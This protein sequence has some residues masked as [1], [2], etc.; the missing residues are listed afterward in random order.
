ML[1][2]MPKNSITALPRLK[3]KMDAVGENLRLA[4]LRRRL[5]ASQVSERAG[6]SRQTLSAAEHGDPGVSFGVYANVLFV[7]GLD[8]DL[9]AL[10]RDDVFGRKLQD[11]GLLVPKRVRRKAAK[12]END[13]A[14]DA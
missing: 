8:S 4:R 3:R 6:I 13:P 11:A 14:N 9:E 1:Y 12:E 2:I 7:L 5:T 10:G